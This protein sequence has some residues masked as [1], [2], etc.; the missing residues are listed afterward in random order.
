MVE[1][2]HVILCPRMPRKTHMLH[3]VARSTRRIHVAKVV[4]SKAML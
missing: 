3:D 4:L 1:V 2:L